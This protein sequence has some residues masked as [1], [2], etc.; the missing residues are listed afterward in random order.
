MRT[1][2]PGREP[3]EIRRLLQ[4]DRVEPGLFEEFRD[5]PMLALDVGGALRIGNAELGGRKRRCCLRRPDRHVAL[6]TWRLPFVDPA[7]R[8]RFRSDLKQTFT[9]TARIHYTSAE[10]RKHKI[11]PGFRM[12]V[13]QHWRLRVLAGLAAGSGLLTAM[14]ADVSA[15]DERPAEKTPSPAAPSLPQEDPD[16]KLNPNVSSLTLGGRQFWA[17]VEYFHQWRI[18][19]NTMTGHFRLLDASDFRHAWGTREQCQA[20]LREIRTAQKLPAMSGEAVILV[21]GIIRSS[22]SM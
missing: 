3:R 7:R 12:N 2:C 5:A 4:D 9:N 22:K 8:Q 1:H 20:K 13:F 18:Q 21:H 11:I 6:S 19:Q 16:V 15:S 10:M 14:A 17:D